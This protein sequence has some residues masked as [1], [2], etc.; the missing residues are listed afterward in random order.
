[1]IRAK[2]RL[3]PLV[4]NTMIPAKTRL[5]PLALSAMLFPLGAMLFAL[6]LGEMLF[7]PEPARAEH[8]AHAAPA[9]AAGSAASTSKQ[10]ETA[11]ALRD[12][13]VGHVFWARNVVVASI[14]KNEQ[15]ATEADKQVVANARAIAKA[16]EP[17]Y[18][19]GAS[20][21]LFGLLAEHYGVVKKLLTS[22]MAADPS[23]HQ[24]A[25]TELNGNAGA[26]AKFLSGANPFLPYDTL[27]AMLL[28][29]GGHH[30]Q[31]IDELLAKDYAKE[32]QTWEAMKNHMHGIADAL[33]GGLAKQFPDKFA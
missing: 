3:S 31:Q 29:H 8:A 21:K 12:L 13:W 14:A 17:Y 15:A 30:I 27:N 26:I 11:A 25:L 32:A 24:A 4:L 18:G 19:S 33:A 6:A 9:P 1:M 10:A 16:V 7:A 2:T 20:E 5:S 28:A 23:A 22:T